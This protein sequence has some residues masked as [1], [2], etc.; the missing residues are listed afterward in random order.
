[1]S[2]PTIPRL[3]VVFLVATLLL[4]SA[5]PAGDFTEPAAVGIGVTAG[6]LWFVPVKAIS[7]TWGLAAG[8]LAYLVFGGDS[9]MARQIWEDSSQGPYLITPEIARAAV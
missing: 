8:S 4:P 1:M 7:V 2:N 5:L 6:N 9:E 3:T